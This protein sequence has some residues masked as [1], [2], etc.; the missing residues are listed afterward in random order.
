[1]RAPTG[2]GSARPFKPA[3]AMHPIEAQV[4]A[5]IGETFPS[6]ADSAQLDAEAS[7]FESGVLDSM[8]VLTLVTWLE[9]TFGI[10]VEDDEV[11]PEN[12]DGIG[13]LVRYIRAKREAAG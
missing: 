10:T 3:T 5:F 2:S 13:P 11:L 6:E 8:G 1:M 12:I 7:L 4:R 9:Q